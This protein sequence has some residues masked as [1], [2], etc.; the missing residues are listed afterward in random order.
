MH[1]IF[2]AIVLAATISSGAAH[3]IVLQGY[4]DCSQSQG[5]SINAALRTAQDLVP[6]ISDG[7]A[8]PTAIGKQALWQPYKT[9]FGAYEPSRWAKVTTA[10]SATATYLTSTVNVEVVC[11]TS[12]STSHPQE[13]A[14][15]WIVNGQ[16]T[17]T[18]F[19][20]YWQLQTDLNRLAVFIEEVV[21]LANPP[22]ALHG[23]PD[24]EVYGEMFCSCLAEMDPDNAVQNPPSYAF[25][26]TDGSTD[27][28]SRDIS[29]RPAPALD[30]RLN[31]FGQPQVCAASFT[32]SAGWCRADTSTSWTCPA[33]TYCGS[34]PNNGP[35]LACLDLFGSV[36][37]SCTGSL[38]P[39][40][41]A[42][43]AN[44]NW[45]RSGPVAGFCGG[46]TTRSYPYFYGCQ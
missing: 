6:H 14:R 44:L 13:V 11:S 9:W 28:C 19:P 32:A 27:D 10:V 35:G 16:P 30:S 40:M 1:T 33:D 43:Y 45:N 39:L 7:F 17:I 21:H 46:S 31:C 8:Y 20:P 15:A 24:T 2:R 3:A 5:Q 25:F 22:P 37:S 29:A 18:L 41:Q 36:P 23:T 42:A 4:Q 34:G 38:T 26:L 12:P